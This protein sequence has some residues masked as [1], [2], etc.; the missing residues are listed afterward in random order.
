MTAY[1]HSRLLDLRGL[2]CP[3]PALKTERALRRATPGDVILVIADD[4]LADI[5][6]PNAAR[7]AH[8]EI[9]SIETRD[10]GTVY[11]IR[12]GHAAKTSAG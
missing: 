9:V 6:I 10:D 4:P 1:R 2:R 3:L 12:R 5:D 11:A 8:S 7:Q